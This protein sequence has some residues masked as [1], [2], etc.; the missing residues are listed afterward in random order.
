MIKSQSL[1]KSTLSAQ[2]PYKSVIL[3]ASAGSG[4]TYQLSQRFLKLVAAGA[5]PH[6][7][8]TVTFTK[9]AASEMSE[10]I[11]EA[12][13][14]L[15]NNQEDQTLFDHEMQVFFENQKLSKA[16][17]KPRNAIQTADLI[18]NQ[19]MPL[20]VTT[21]DGIF[22]QWCTR[23]PVES[24]TNS[25][26][27]LI[28]KY[29]KDRLT[30][31]AWQKTWQDFEAKDPKLVTYLAESFPDQGLMAIR[32]QIEK[33]SKFE[34]FLWLLS[35]KGKS[36]QEI[37]L[38][39]N[40][41]VQW[42]ESLVRGFKQVLALLGPAA[43][44]NVAAWL[45]G[46]KGYESLIEAK[47]ISK[48]SKKLSGTYFKKAVMSKDPVAFQEIEA[49]LE[50]WKQYYFANH[51]N[52]TAKL[53]S[54]VYS[55]F[56]ANYQEQKL[57]HQK[58]EFFDKTLGAFRIYNDP[59]SVGA[60]FFIHHGI[61]HLMIDE[62]QDTSLIQWEI[63]K[64]IAL[65]LLSGEG[66]AGTIPTVFI[67]G[68]LK[69]SIYEFRDAEPGILEGLE[70]ELPTAQAIEMSRSYRSSQTILDFVNQVFKEPS[71]LN[72]NNFPHHDRALEPIYGQI[73]IGSCFE[74]QTEPSTE[75][76]TET[77]AEA[78][79]PCDAHQD[80]HPKTLE[81]KEK[82]MRIIETKIIPKIPLLLKTPR[83]FRTNTLTSLT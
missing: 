20:Q 68:D 29:E 34:S 32:N 69:Q 48:S 72:I 46:N 49:N 19:S 79:P 42:Q 18:L 21:M 17:E 56:S 40:Q 36:I 44:K 76:A 22:S 62:F 50:S 74:K 64:K 5:E 10:R 11:L 6:R 37:S 13:K 78:L 65:E 1:E 71:P 27:L 7:I 24:Q 52:N 77:N 81:A 15:K 33:L 26:C 60:R 80:E 41:V 25:E 70:A 2:N 9:K 54:M 82:R 67:V 28:N 3:K 47:I 8:L 35:Y 23:F 61:E 39:E 63:F 31:H 38:P 83:R 57:K 58:F 30:T 75:L 59:M 16:G 53:L 55:M 43:T 14:N 4:K 51:L 45:E 66:I 12:A 73:L